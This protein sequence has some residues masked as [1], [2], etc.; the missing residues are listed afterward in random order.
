MKQTAA[1][2]FTIHDLGGKLVYRQ[3]LILPHGKNLI[4]IDVEHL[5]S[6]NYVA[7]LIVDQKIAVAKTFIKL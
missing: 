4:Q 7:N 1:G 2:E 5:R 6:G 3:S